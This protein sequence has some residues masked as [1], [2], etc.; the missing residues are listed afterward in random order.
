[1]KLTIETMKYIFLVMTAFLFLNT[2]CKKKQAKKIEK[3]VEDKSIL[4]VGM[5]SGSIT[6]FLNCIQDGG[7]SFGNLSLPNCFNDAIISPLSL[8][9][10]VST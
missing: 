7:S 2:G 9:S 8:L 10:I 4:D 3:Y 5:G 1:V 6:F